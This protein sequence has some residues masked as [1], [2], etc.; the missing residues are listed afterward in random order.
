MFCSY[1]YIAAD[2]DIMH[3]HLRDYSVKQFI[4]VSVKRTGMLNYLFF[5]FISYNNYD[6][7]YGNVMTVCRS[8]TMTLR[9]SVTF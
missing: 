9:M 1:L 5:A 2:D 8:K 6:T 7:L 3:D 4:V